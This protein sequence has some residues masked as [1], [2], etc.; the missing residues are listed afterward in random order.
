MYL[1]DR[2]NGDAFQQHDSRLQQGLNAQYTHPHR[3]GGIAAVFV[4]GS[5]F[6]D[7]EINVGLY[8]RQG[9]TP[10]GVT[11]RANAHVTNGAGYAQENVSPFGGRLLLGAG[12]RYDG[13]RFDVADRVNLV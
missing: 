6:H 8:P 2:V 13:F 3:F 10:T 7:N 5:N 12:I 11:T 4:A 1:N 9:R